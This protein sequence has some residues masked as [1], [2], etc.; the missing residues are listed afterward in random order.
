MSTQS[1][2]QGSVH[3]TNESPSVLCGTWV[4]FLLLGN[5]IL[6]SFPSGEGKPAEQ[7]N[8]RTAG[9]ALALVLNSDCEDH[10]AGAQFY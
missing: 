2:F 5:Q 9:L 6:T 7:Q 1:Y 4:Y 10:C 3:L 8:V